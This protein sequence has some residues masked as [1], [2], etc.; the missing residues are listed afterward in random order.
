M[1]LFCNFNSQST[2]I[3]LVFR[4][5]YI[6]IHKSFYTSSQNIQKIVARLL[7]ENFHHLTENLYFQILGRG[8]LG[9]TKLYIHLKRALKFANIPVFNRLFMQKKGKNNALCPRLKVFSVIL[10]FGTCFILIPDLLIFSVCRAYLG[11]FKILNIHN[12]LS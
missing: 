12:I 7:K 11:F 2:N 5:Q 4:Q 3:L 6:Y 9:T 8:V 1:A 10:L